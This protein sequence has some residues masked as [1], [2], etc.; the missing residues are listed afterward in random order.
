MRLLKRNTTTFEYEPNTGEESDLDEN[1]N[2]TGDYQPV[3]GGPVEKK[4]NISTPSGY[5]N[6][7][8]FGQDIRYTHV[9]VMD[10]IDEDINEDGRI[11]WKG[12]LY[13][14]RAVRPSLN[15]LSVALRKQTVNHEAGSTDSQTE[16]TDQTG[17][18]D[19]DGE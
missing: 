4:G 13:D 2:H 3:F 5:T 10:H 15:V 17:E 9:L 7:T 11:R 14:I 8:F 16:E 1:G 18:Q 19:G 6:Q 12:D